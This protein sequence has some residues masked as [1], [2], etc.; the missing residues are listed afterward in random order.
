M[1]V[2]W[3]KLYIDMFDNRKIKMMKNMPEGKSI[4]LIWI[5]LIVLAG[6][7]ND[8][9]AIYFT[10]EIPYTDEMLAIAFEEKLE[11]VRMA[12]NLFKK[13]D[14]IDIVEDV[15][16][17][18]NWSKYQS[19]DNLEKQKELNSKRVKEYRQRLSLIGGTAYQKHFSTLMLRDEAKCV[20]C[21]SEEELV[22]DH[23]IPIIQGGD[24]N[25]DNLVMCCKKCNSGKSGR[26]VEE[27]KYKIIN[28]N[29]K[30]MYE[31]TKERILIN[32]VT[33]D[34]TQCHAI[35]IDKEL[36]IELDKEDIHIRKSKYGEYKNVSLTDDEF[37]KITDKRAI[38]YLSEYKQ[39]T[40][41]KYKSDYLAIKKWVYDALKEKKNPYQKEA[42]V[43]EWYD[44][45]AENQK[46]K[47][48]IKVEAKSTEELEKEMENWK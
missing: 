41:K 13:F 26:L 35:D 47:A 27:A 36:D 4:L 32:N 29:V 8:S 19:L 12:L 37:A 48:K 45:Y 22:I 2:K 24:N 25:I 7:I 43:P 30:K 11:V 5:Q 14:M 46:N 17:L 1:E 38:E 34:V 20:Y 23:L 9:G 18:S 44:K 33:Q 15:I 6:Q 31:K 10:R 21:G 42:P 3:V 39:M 16:Y 40:G 28:Q